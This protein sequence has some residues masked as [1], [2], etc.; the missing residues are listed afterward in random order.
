MLNEEKI[1][2]MIKMAVYEQGEGKKSIPMS[3]YYKSDYMSL[4]IIN[5]V[6][7]TTIVY[8]AVLAA[9]IFVNVEKLL[10]ELVTLDFLV[11]GKKLLVA[12]FII[13]A[14]NLLMTYIVNFVRFKKYRRGLNEYNRHLKRLYTITKQESK[15]SAKK[16]V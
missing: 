10:E 16:L 2:L 13:L 5:S 6:I 14:V 4:R 1:A 12:Y 9:V 7:V 3:K 11:I 15:K 8:F